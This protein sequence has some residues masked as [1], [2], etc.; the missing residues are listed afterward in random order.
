[1]TDDK[2]DTQLLQFFILKK[3]VYIN[4]FHELGEKFLNKKDLVTFDENRRISRDY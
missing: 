3:N 4:K 2:K 1:M